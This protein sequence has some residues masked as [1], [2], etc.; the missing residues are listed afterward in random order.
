MYSIGFYSVPNFFVILFNLMY[1][2][3]VVGIYCKG[4]VIV[5]ESVKTQTIEV[6]RVF[7]GISRLS[8]LQKDACALHMTGM[9]RVSTDGDSCVSRVRPSRETLARHFVLPACLV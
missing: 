3:F 1:L 5:R 9:Q 7:A 6:R 2:V 8:I 4:C